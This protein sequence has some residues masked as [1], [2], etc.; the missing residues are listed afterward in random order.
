M[1]FLF[2]SPISNSLETLLGHFSRHSPQPVHFVSS[3]N[4]A[5]FSTFTLKLPTLPSMPTTSAYVITLVLGWLKQSA[6]LGAR[7]HIEQSF[8]GNVLSSWAILPPMLGVF[9]T[10]WTIIPLSARSRS[11][12][13]PATPPPI[14]ITDFSIHR[15]PCHLVWHE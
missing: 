12:W 6:I 5:F 4:R 11:A 2:A 14:T 10:M 7:M 15:P 13:I 9:S 8:V 3:T 1:A